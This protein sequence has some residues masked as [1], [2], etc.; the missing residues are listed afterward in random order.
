MK[1]LSIGVFLIIVVTVLF[2]L[3]SISISKAQVNQLNSLPE[4]VEYVIE[5]YGAVMGEA[6]WSHY[7]EEWG[8]LKKCENPI[9]VKISLINFTDEY[10]DEFQIYWK[11]SNELGKYKILTVD[12]TPSDRIILYGEKH[13]G[14]PKYIGGKLT[15]AIKT[16]TGDFL[17]V[18]TINV[19]EGDNLYKFKVERRE[20][21]NR[22]E[23]KK[24]PAHRSL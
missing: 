14:D 23:E 8:H 9:A 21:K 17:D 3:A 24:K 12:D 15:L 13:G 4:H 2:C 1:K 6:E 7:D 10:Y 16:T 5:Y 19:I 20:F 22:E 11:H 18:K